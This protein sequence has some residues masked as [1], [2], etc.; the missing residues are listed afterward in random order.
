MKTHHK[1]TRTTLPDRPLTEWIGIAVGI[2]LTTYLV[3][4]LLVNVF[5][6]VPA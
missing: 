6:V 4:V 2:A 3:A 1:I 5:T